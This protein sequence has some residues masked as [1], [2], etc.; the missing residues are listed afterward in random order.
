LGERANLT[1]G[2]SRLEEIG[3]A[4]RLQLLIDSIVDYA[5]FMLDV[6]GTIRSWNS[7]AA[8]LKGYSAEEI[9]GRHFSIFYTLKIS[10]TTC[11]S[12]R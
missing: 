6:N 8:R 11:R 3:D 9:I 5:I 1:K 4:R 7:G 12:G 10:P 2:Q